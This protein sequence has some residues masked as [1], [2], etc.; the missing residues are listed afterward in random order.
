MAALIWIAA[1]LVVLVMLAL[2]M[3]WH[4]CFRGT[5]QP[6]ALRLHLR[7]LGGH[8]PGIPIPLARSAD[9]KGA[10]RSRK[11]RRKRAMPRGLPD[12]VLGLLSAFRVRR[13]RL[14]G[15]FGLPDPA[16]TGTLWGCL[17]PVIYGLSGGERRIDIAPEFS[18]A[19]LDLT[20]SGELLIHPLRLLRAG[21]A[22][23]W[24]NRGAP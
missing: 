12:L 20:G 9:R 5:T 8:A 6:F 11:D 10:R 13:L 18:G 24:A 1:A 14:T 7:L 2:L 22:F 23:A 15:R 4:L 19:C 17:T 3:P 21:L 16:D